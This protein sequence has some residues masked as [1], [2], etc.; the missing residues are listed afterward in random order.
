MLNIIK[1]PYPLRHL[2]TTTAIL[3]VVAALNNINLLQ[4]IT[5]LH[6]CGNRSFHVAVAYWPKWP[7][8]LPQ[9][10]LHCGIRHLPPTTTWKLPDS[11]ERYR[12][13][14]IKLSCLVFQST[15]LHWFHLNFWL[16]LLFSARLSWHTSA[17][18]LWVLNST[19]THYYH[20]THLSE[21]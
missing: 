14:L 18:S 17:Y 7:S 6:P 3:S 19:H 15:K 12:N 11:C 4:C 5:S 20:Y 10:N 2:P 8:L 13:Q 21:R 1:Q 16:S 9:C